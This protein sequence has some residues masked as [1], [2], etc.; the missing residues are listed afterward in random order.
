VTGCCGRKG[1]RRSAADDPER[2]VDTN[3]PDRMALGGDTHSWLEPTVCT[4]CWRCV[5]RGEVSTPE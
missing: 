3:E 5:E 2:I 1:K 4:P